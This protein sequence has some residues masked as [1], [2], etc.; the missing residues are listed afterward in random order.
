M[1]EAR[2]GFPAECPTGQGGLRATRHLRHCAGCRH[3]QHTP[4]PHCTW[5]EVAPEYIAA[6]AEMMSRLTWQPQLPGL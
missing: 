6:I 3:I 2:E 4:H 5:P 1:T